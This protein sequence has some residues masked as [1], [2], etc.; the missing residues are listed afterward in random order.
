M[1]TI[2]DVAKRAGVSVATVSRVLNDSGYADPDTRARVLRAAS[3][4]DYQR[5]IHWSRLKS[6]SSRTILF[7]LGNRD[8]LN[9]MHTR[10]L[11]ACERFFR[12]HD[13]DLI[14]ARHEYTRTATAKELVLPRVLQQQGAVDGVLLVGI[15]HPN[16]LQVLDRR[17]LLYTMLGNDF[18]GPAKELERNCVIY[19]D[20]GAMEQAT[21]YLQRLGHR[22]IAFIGNRTQPWFERRYQGYRAAMEARSLEPHGVF[23]HWTLPSH[24]YG[25]VAMAQL[26]KEPSPPTAVVTGNDELAAGAWKELNQRRIAIPREISL[27]S[28][29]DRQEYSILDLTSISVFVDQLGERLS[30]M[31]LTRI[32]D[33]K[34]S[35]ATEVFPCKLMERSSCGPCPAGVRVITALERTRA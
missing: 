33:P 15:H 24:D 10:L 17:K 13:Y 22:R 9:P 12:A 19:D 14:L 27:L 31:L 21:G 25:Q 5:N 32:E 35:L 6:K 34:Q 3:E 7:L 8:G 23:D 29:G 20:R 11:M 30:R 26:L 18:S 1:A 2:V 4:L 28:I 16:L